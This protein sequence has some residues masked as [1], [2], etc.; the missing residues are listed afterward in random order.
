[1]A[2]VVLAAWAGGCDR[3]ADVPKERAGAASERTSASVSP[4]EV[5]R[6]VDRGVGLMGAFEFIEAERAFADAAAR[7]PSSYEAR[8]GQ[9]IAVLNQSSEGAQ[10]RAIGLLGSVL[11]QWP[12]DPRASHCEGL[13]WLYLGEPA[14]ALSRFR[15]AVERVPSD[16][17][18]NFYVGQCCELLGEAELASASYARAAELDPYLRSAY[19]GMQRVLAR[20]GKDAQADAMLAEF[21]RQAD[22]PRSHLAEFKYTRMGAL[23]EAVVV[24][25]AAPAPA[26]PAGAPFGPVAPFPIDGWPAAPLALDELQPAADLDGDGTLD[27]VATFHW[28]E[29][30]VIERRIV[31]SRPAGRWAVDPA[32]TVGLRRGRMLWGDLD[33]DGRVDVAFASAIGSHLTIAT[34]LHAGWCRQL[35][36]GSW[37]PYEFR[38]ALIPEDDLAAIADLDH[39]GDLDF[40][41]TGGCQTGILWNLGRPSA[42]EPV[43]WER[44][45][46]PMALAPAMAAPADLDGDGD[47]DLLL[48]SRSGAE[49]QAWC[50]D[51]LWAWSRAPG[52]GEFE[53]SRPTQVVAFRDGDDGEPVIATIS[54]TAPGDAVG[55]ETWRRSKGA[56]QRAS[57][58]EVPGAESLW[59]ADIAGCG[60]ANVVVQ[61]AGSLVVLDSHG[62]PI[63]RIEGAPADSVPCVPDARGPVAV[64]RRSAAGA[65][66]AWLPPGPG[67]GAFAALWLKGRTDPS[68]QMRS[69]VSGIGASVD[70]RVAG[71]WVASDALPW[72]GSGAQ[73]LEPVLVG[74][75]GASKCD[76]VRIEWPDAVLQSELSVPAGTRTIT[77]TQRQI[78]S[79]PVIF[80]WNGREH[81]FVTDCLGVGGIG[82][83]AGIERAPNGALRPVYPPP[84][85]RERVL[86]GG[87]D[88]LAPVDGLYDVRLGEPMEEACYLDAVALEAIDVPEGWSVALDERMGIN[89]PQPTGEARFWRRSVAPARAVARVAG[90]ESNATSDIVTPDGRAADLGP[91]DPRFI[92][93]LAAEATLECSFDDAIDAGAGDPMLVIDGWVEYPYSSTGFGMWQAQAPYQAPTLEARDPASGTWVTLV[94]EYGYPA[95]MPRRC[96]LPVPSDTLPRGCRELRLRTTMEVYVDAVRLAWAEPCP[97]AV[98]H[99]ATLAGVTMAD[100]GFA[101]RVPRPQRRPDYDYARRTP[102]WDCRVQPGAYTAFGDCT[103]LLAGVDDAVAI[104]GAGEEVRLSFDARSVPAPSPGMRRTWVLDVAGWCK[105][106]DL[107]TGSGA[108]LDPLP[109]RDGASPGAERDRLHRRHNVRWNGGR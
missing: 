9:G 75:G 3:N 7:M 34:G 108:T 106:M 107:H 98:R 32:P 100:A 1:V 85:P 54:S 62:Q 61:E 39:D 71:A 68:Q 30:G 73:A 31:R 46:L 24:R 11:G 2:W 76:F 51:R 88:A 53:A 36:D 37:Q 45:V 89:G 12:D 17:H 66:P 105:D 69:N 79:C 59:V 13:A 91:A 10:E 80:A 14:K 92:G 74:L 47:L 70:A 78:S 5:A 63:E 49:A 83:L 65:V 96:I 99:R 21:R 40:V 87:P 48:W 22:N 42:D 86:I 33:N 109:V 56:W 94:P 52:F 64:S 44:Q 18:A 72:R 20:Q 41:F 77:E 82:Y 101:R 15:R 84:R 16:P 60:H 97:D 50:N 81:A 35:S 95:G 67:R 23:G 19:L 4:A 103:E 29:E 58:I 90:C 6:E 8:L 27:F 38:G 25:D 55:A 26:A 57:R 28:P 104:F 93:R 102:L 43:A